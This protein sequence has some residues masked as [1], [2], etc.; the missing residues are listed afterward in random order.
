MR[1]VWLQAKVVRAG[2]RLVWTEADV[3][4]DGEP[5]GKFAATG[6]RVAFDRQAYLNERGGVDGRTR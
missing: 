6:I 5:A 2:S 4:A 3:L 1:P